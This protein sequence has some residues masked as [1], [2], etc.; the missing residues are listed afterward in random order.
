VLAWRDASCMR[1]ACTGKQPC[2]HKKAAP[3]W[4]PPIHHPKKLF[5]SFKDSVNFKLD[6]IKSTKSKVPTFIIPNNYHAYNNLAKY[7]RSKSI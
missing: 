7:S 4:M 5:I 6:Q 2:T 1:H 3:S